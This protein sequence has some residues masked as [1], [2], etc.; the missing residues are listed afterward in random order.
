M[1]D[2]SNQVLNIAVAYLGPAAKQFLERQCSAHLNTS[3]D[4]LSA[5]EIPELGKWIN[6]SAGLVIGKDKAE[7]FSNKVLGLK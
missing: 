7:E 4:N 1:S 5:G 3:F 6:I 2:L